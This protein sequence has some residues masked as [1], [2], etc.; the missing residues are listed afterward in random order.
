MRQTGASPTDCAARA[1]R[2]AADGFG[3]ARSSAADGAAARRFGLRAEPSVPAAAI[4]AFE[5]A[6]ALRA[7]AAAAVAVDGRCAR[8]VVAPGFAAAAAEDDA[9]GAAAPAREDGREDG[10]EVGRDVGRED[11]L[12]AGAGALAGAGAVRGRCVDRAAAATAATAAARRDS[13]VAGAS[14]GG[15]DGW[16][17]VAIMEATRDARPPAAPS[18]MSLGFGLSVA[19]VALAVAALEVAALAVEGVAFGRESRSTAAAAAL[20]FGLAEVLAPGA[21]LARARPGARPLLARAAART[22]AEGRRVSV[23]AAAATWDVA[24]MIRRR[25]AAAASS[26]AAA[27]AAS[28]AAA[29]AD[30]SAVAAAAASSAAAVAGDEAA[31]V[32]QKPLQGFGAVSCAAAASTRARCSLLSPSSATVTSSSS[33]TTTSSSSPTAAAAA[34]APMSDPHSA[35]D[36]RGDSRG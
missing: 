10:R 18:V 1:S 3:R 15:S 33:A 12:A 31:S 20:A 6:Y 25:G 14:G 5:R 21:G 34:V 2:P 36:T 9:V 4:P 27:A 8:T 23:P 17:S 30:A 28:C 26:C 22:L 29:A 7:G 16:A 35:G 11:A 19:G 24:P 32:A 13:A